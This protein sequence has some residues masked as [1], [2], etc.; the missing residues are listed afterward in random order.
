MKTYIILIA[1]IAGVLVTCTPQQPSVPKGEYLIQGKLENVPDSILIQLFENGS[2]ALMDTLVNG[3]F[4]FR[5]TASVPRI[6]DIRSSRS[7]GFPSA[8]LEVWVT[9]GKHIKIYGQ[10]NLIKT[11]AIESDIPEQQEENRYNALAM[12]ETKELMKYSIVRN[13]LRRELSKENDPDLRSKIRAKADSISKLMSP[14]NKA[15]QKKELDYMKTAPMTNIW[16]NKLLDYAAFIQN[17]DSICKSEIKGLYMRMTDD[18]K[19][20]AIGLE[21]RQHLYPKPTVGIGDEMADG[22]LYDME[23]KLRHISEFKGKYI[24][25]DFWNSGCSGCVASIP[26]I[27]ELTT[28]YRDKLVVI[29]ISDDPKRKWKEFI[30]EKKMNGNQWNEHRISRTGL[31]ARYRLDRWPYYVLINQEGKIQDVW[32]GGEDSPLRRVN[33][34]FNK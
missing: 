21:I 20:T 11:W 32:S 1:L 6:V 7:K 22:D 2:C 17:K 13:N 23:D 25:L 10:D 18:Q 27:E 28:M 16:V 33:Q 12:P 15:I 26:E 9:S 4:I 34:V 31:A 8:S 30:S 5:D 24:L 14:L 19:Q 3:E 29:G